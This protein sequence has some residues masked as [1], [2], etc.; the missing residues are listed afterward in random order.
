VL[1][2]LDS[3]LE[4]ISKIKQTMFAISATSIIQAPIAI[5]LS[6][7]LIFHPSF[8]KM[9]DNR[10]DFGEALVLL[11]AVVIATSSYWFVTGIRNYRSMLQWSKQYKQFVEDK[12]ERER[13]IAIKYGLE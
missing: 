5:V 2:L 3:F 11:F 6:T 10:D 12:Q 13:Q 1:V 9:I 7:Y 8:L 4:Q